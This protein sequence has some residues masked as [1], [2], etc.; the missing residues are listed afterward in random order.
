MSRR[1]LITF[2]VVAVIVIFFALV[3]TGVIP[4]L[5]QE[6]KTGAVTLTMWGVFDSPQAF[7]AVIGAYQQKFS[8]IRINYRQFAP[9]NYER[10]LV[11]AL[12]AGKG[13][14]MFMVHNTWLPK[15]DDKMSPLP[16]A[17]LPIATFR[18]LFPRVVEQDFAPD[19]VIYALPLYIDTLALY[20]NKDLFDNAGIAVPPK[21]WSEVAALIP[22][23][24]VIDRKG[25]VTRAGAAIGGTPR[26]VNRATD[27]LALLMMQAGAPMV[28]PNFSRA[29]LT[30]KGGRTGLDFYTQFADPKNSA[31]TWNDNLH[32]S[33]DAFAEGGAA[34]MFNY[35][36]NM[37]ALKQKNPFLAF[38][39]APMPQ[40]ANA[41]A[42]VDYPNYF[43]LA[44]AAKSRAQSAAWNFIRFL[45][46][47]EG[48]ARTYL[49]ATKHPPALRTLIA[50]NA[51]DPDIGMF[52]NQALTA[53]S[54]PQIDNI[55]VER[56]M[57]ELLENVVYGKLD[58][59]RAL[60]QAEAAITT[61]MRQRA[62]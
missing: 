38:G 12:A 27:L 33:L 1:L 49:S 25:A 31:Y 30:S 9:E 36:Y 62:K 46:T 43:G 47:E 24:R 37:N 58:K 28:A 56:I 14:D 61:V 16:A 50:A 54:Y 2:G 5:K 41:Q 17:S 8:N 23:L 48:A 13:P 29:D 51:N 15:H 10:E 32:Y 52:T 39:V 59:Q 19:G 6:I 22:K 3:F 55:E 4:G 11:N 44:V 35:A 18:A 45:T 57:G 34:M 60:E 20:Y 7:A 53:R 42:R 26:S 21:N 40:P